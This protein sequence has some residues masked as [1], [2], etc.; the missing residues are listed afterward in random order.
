MNQRILIA[1]DDVSLRLLL[2]ATL[3]DS[4]VDLLEAQ[5]GLQA[6]LL[7]QQEL[8]DLILLDV[9]MPGMTGL[10]VCRQLKLDQRTAEIPVVMISAKAKP[11]DEDAG[12]EAGAQSYLTKPFS[13]LDLL[14]LIER[15]LPGGSRESVGANPPGRG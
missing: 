2:S 7:A 9:A 14:R 5:D 6:L 15:L 8:P 13:P 1:D 10:E 11:L 12:L 3:S 4:E